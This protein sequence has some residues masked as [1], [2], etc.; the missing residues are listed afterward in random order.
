MLTALVFL[1]ALGALLLLLLPNELMRGT[2]PRATMGREATRGPSTRA[3]TGLA[4]KLGAA[5]VTLADLALALCLWARFDTTSTGVQ[6]AEKQLWVPGLNIHY[7]LGI[8]GLSLPMVLLTTLLGFLAVLI[9]WNIEHRVKLYFA[10]LLILETGI[11]GVFTALDFVLF[12]LFWEVELL[13]MFLLIAVWGSPPPLGRREYS[14]WKF[15]LYTFF[16][17]AFMLM[18]LLALYWSSGSFNLIE[19]REMDLTR[20]TVPAAL[21][22]WSIF[23]AFA[24]KLP[25]FPFHTWLPDAHTDAPTAASV[26]LA[27]VLLKMGG[28][29][30]V[31]ICISLFPDVAAAWAPVLA[32]FAV[33]NV[34]YGA[35]LTLRQTDLKRLVAYSSVSHMGYVLLGL[36]ALGEVGMTGAVLQ[37][38]THGTITGLLFALVGL[39]YDKTHTRQIPE[40]RGLAHRMPFVAT[41]FGIAALAS[42]GLPTMSGFVAEFLVFA[43]TY[44]A[45]GAY[46]VLGTAGVVLAAAYMLWVVERSFFQTTSRHLHEVRDATLLERVAPA[47]LVASIM[48]VGLWPRVLLDVIKTGLGPILA[49]LG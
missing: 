16:G 11:L 46:T 21:I 28:Y 22:F 20:T 26:I 23:L 38:F 25:V 6:F 45:F 14:A 42:L 29:G 35:L 8:D 33:V 17:S 49:R 3:T 2:S 5:A 32:L 27:G 18:G 13:P 48:V 36:A 34:L 1:P 7:F 30:M 12:F 9:S 10:V 4:T 41:V 40:L 15:L 24:I 39:V 37:M 31:R 19:L 47:A 43:G 44:P